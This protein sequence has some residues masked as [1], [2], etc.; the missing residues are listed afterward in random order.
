MTY[1]KKLIL[2][3]FEATGISPLNE[4]CV[5][6]PEE[7][8]H[9]TASTIMAE[10]KQREFFVP[11]TPKHGRSILIHGRKT[12]AAL[13]KSSPKSRY[14]HALVEKLF[15]AAA[16]VKADNVILTI[17]N[18]NLRHKATSAAD[19]EK[20]KKGRRCQKHVLFL[21]K[22]CSE[23]VRNIK[24]QMKLMHRKKQRLLNAMQPKRQSSPHQY[25]PPSPSETPK[26][27]LLRSI[28]QIFLN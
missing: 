9:R 1:T 26:R 3:A 11:K 27:L 24:K 10:S 19:K 15:N 23:Y 21:F 5:L 20:T 22:M 13:P 4:R 2:S 8:P 7:K 25:Q 28:V 16:Q 17:E 6:P 18:Q 14:H 12:L